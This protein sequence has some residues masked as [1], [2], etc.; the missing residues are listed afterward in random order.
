[1]TGH[2]FGGPYP[3]FPTKLVGVCRFSLVV[4]GGLR[5]GRHCD[6]SF[7]LVQSTLPESSTAQPL[8]ESCESS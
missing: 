5:V 7:F 1:M 4:N 6:S 2:H 3:L 8:H